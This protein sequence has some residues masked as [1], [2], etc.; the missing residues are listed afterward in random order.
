MLVN[1][2]VYLIVNRC[3]SNVLE[4]EEY[5]REICGSLNN[6]RGIPVLNV[7]IYRYCAKDRIPNGNNEDM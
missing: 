3:T 4:K 1:A 6:Q 2:L 7:F 5:E